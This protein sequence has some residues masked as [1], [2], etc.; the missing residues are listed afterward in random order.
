MLIW[1]VVLGLLG[2]TKIAQYPA[3]LLA[4]SPLYA[5]QFLTS[6]PLH[7]LLIILGFVMLVVTG[8][9]AMYADLGHFG[10]TPIRVSWLTLAYPALVLNYLGQGAYLLSGQPV[11]N[12]SIFYSMAPSWALLPLIGL[13][14]LAT[15]IASQALITGSFSLASQASTLNL[16]P[17]FVTKHTHQD[18]VGQIFLPVINA[19][20]YIGCVTLVLLFKNST[21]LASAYGL[22]VSGVMLVT[23]LAVAVLAYYDWKWP[24][25]IV[26]SLFIPFGLIDATFVLA[27]SL[28]FLEGGFV[29]LAIGF[30][31][32]FVMQSW[33]WGTAKVK[34]ALHES[35]LKTVADLL[36]L[37]QKNLVFSPRT[38]VFM[39]PEFIQNHTDELPPIKE[40]LD[41]HGV[42]PQHIVFLTVKTKHY[43]TLSNRE[44]IEIAPIDVDV[45]HGTIISVRLNAGFM[46]EI[47]LKTLLKKVAAQYPQ[48]VDSSIDSWVFHVA[49]RQIIAEQLSSWFSQLKFAIFSFLQQTSPTASEH[50]ELSKQFKVTA[51]VIPVRIK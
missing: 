19:L 24:L 48:A 10:R 49:H 12:G 37:R 14:T 5:I 16:L 7:E 40:L 39:T 46:E 29:P 23:T 13:S 25:A 6:M 22:A 33:Q 17:Y 21:N 1:F 26:L 3:V 50:F 18:H 27:N 8:G 28:K 32:M 9:E 30:A 44:R 38:T 43:P 4:L 47:Q 20:L 15:I 31:L 11:L 41:R 42:Y 34:K 45:A 2:L 51:E 35:D 36:K